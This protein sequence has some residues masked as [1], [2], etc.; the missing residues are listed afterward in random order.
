[1]EIVGGK[2][3]GTRWHQ[4]AITLEVDG[5]LV[6]RDRYAGKGWRDWYNDPEN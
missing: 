2:V 4:I 1:V 6:M 3:L 5:D